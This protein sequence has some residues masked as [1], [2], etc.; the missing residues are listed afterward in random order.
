MITSIQFHYDSSLDK[1]KIFVT[2]PTSGDEAKQ[3]LDKLLAYIQDEGVVINQ[4]T[5]IAPKLYEV[6]EQ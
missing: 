1:W 5:E 6:E 3:G 2:G 4:I